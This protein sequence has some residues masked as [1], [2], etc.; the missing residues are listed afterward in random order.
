MWCIDSGCTHHVSCTKEDMT[1]YV[2]YRTPKDV[3]LG[4]NSVVQA[5]GEGTKHVMVS[6]GGKRMTLDLQRCMHI[7][8]MAKN[9]FSVKAATDYAAGVAFTGSDCTVTTRDGAELKVGHVQNNLYMLNT[10]NSANLAMVPGNEVPDL[11]LWHLRLAHLGADGVRML[12]D[13]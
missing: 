4:D 6:A 8:K 3:Y 10:A 11:G 1:D 13:K 9:L 12:A 2:G 7:P 5:V